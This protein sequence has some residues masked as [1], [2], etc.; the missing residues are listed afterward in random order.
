MGICNSKEAYLTSPKVEKNM[1]NFN[2]SVNTVITNI[3][4]KTNE[5]VED[6]KEF[7]DDVKDVTIEI[8]EGV[9]DLVEDVSAFVKRTFGAIKSK[10]PKDQLKASQY[11]ARNQLAGINEL[12]KRV[13]FRKDL[14][15]VRDQG[16]IGSCVAQVCACI[17][18]YQEFIETGKKMQ[19][20]VQFIYDLR[21]NRKIRGMTEGMTGYDAMTILLTRGACFE[22]S[23]PYGR[24]LETTTI[25][26]QIF[27]EAYRFRTQQFMYI[28]TIDSLKQA[29]CREGP[30][31]AI[32]PVYGAYDSVE[33]WKP[34][35]DSKRMTGYHAVTI[36]GYF[37]DFQDTSNNGFLVRNSWSSKWG[38]NGYAVL[39]YSDCSF[40]KCPA[41]VWSTIDAPNT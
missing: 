24:S 25:P 30:C 28:D 29:L 39:K 11:Y 12:P 18:E 41:E 32:M 21:G 7:A 22:N 37:D 34:S 10:I 17:K 1:S 14:F 20:S 15:P 19:Y 35:R 16:Q 23:Y 4:N 6:A 9:K 2:N 3:R 27:D 36:V 38:D 13:D 5:T 8:T 33:F 40:G 31:L 26:K